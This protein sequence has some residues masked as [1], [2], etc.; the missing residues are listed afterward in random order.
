MPSTLHSNNYQIF[1]TLL[2]NA[3]TDA[4]LTQVNIAE[5]LNKP[6]SYV[7][8]YERGERRLDFPEFIEL[9]EIMGI[10]IAKFVDAYKASITNVK[11]KNKRNR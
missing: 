10:D 11:H 7:S 4:G 2:I 5:K 1:R 8:K 3:R 6:Q 9:A